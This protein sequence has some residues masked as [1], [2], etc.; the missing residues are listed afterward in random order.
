LKLRLLRRQTLF[1][2]E[3]RAL[4][5]QFLILQTLALLSDLLYE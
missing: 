4:S 1:P 3:L 5:A 2:T